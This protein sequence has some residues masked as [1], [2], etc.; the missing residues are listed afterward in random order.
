MNLQPDVFKLVICLNLSQ[1]PMGAPFWQACT[2]HKKSPSVF[3]FVFYDKIANA[4]NILTWEHYPSALA[5]AA[6]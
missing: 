1:L 6:M 4:E 2:S 5:S 3:L